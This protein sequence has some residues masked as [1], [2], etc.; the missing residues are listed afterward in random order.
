MATSIEFEGIPYDFDYFNR[1]YAIKQDIDKA[2]NFFYNNHEM[3]ALIEVMKFRDDFST[4][5]AKYKQLRTR[6]DN[7]YK[8]KGYLKDGWDWDKLKRNYAGYSNIDFDEHYN[9]YKENILEFEKLGGDTVHEHLY[10][11]VQS[12]K[13][14]PNRRGASKKK[15]KNKRNPKKSKNKRNSKKSRNKRNI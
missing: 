8:I 2:E 11:M 13:L 15:S 7:Q 6:A 9:N 1:I 4:L 14:V 3:N 10:I 12:G 5:P